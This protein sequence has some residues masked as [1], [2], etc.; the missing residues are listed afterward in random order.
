MRCGREGRGGIFNVGNRGFKWGRDKLSEWGVW[1][2]IV[3]N[4]A[5]NER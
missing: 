4:R 1:V 3:G 2:F 5:L